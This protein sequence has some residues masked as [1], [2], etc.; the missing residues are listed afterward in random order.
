MSEKRVVLFGQ[1]LGS[2]VAMAMADR[3]LAADGIVLL[4]P[5]LS[6]SKMASLSY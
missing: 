5:F 1:S 6:I 2:A 3:G 4:S